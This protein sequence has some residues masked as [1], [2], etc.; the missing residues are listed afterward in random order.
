MDSQSS[1]HDLLST[2]LDGSNF[3]LWK[4][5]FGIFVQGK[6]LF[7]LLDGSARTPTDAKELDLWKLNNAKLEQDQIL[8]QNIF[9]AGLKEVLEERKKTR[10]VQFLMKLRPE[11]EP[12]RGSLLNREVTPALN[13]V[14]A[15]VLR[16]ETRLGTQVAMESTPLPSVALLAG[17]STTVASTGNTKRSVQCYEWQDFGHIAANCPKKKNICAYCKITGHHISDCRR[18]PNRSRTAHQAYQTNVTTSSGSFIAGHDFEKLIRDSIAA[19]LPEAISSALSASSSGT[20]NSINS[21]WHLDSGASNHMTGDLSQFSSLSSGVSKHVIH[22][23][24]GHTLPASG[25]GSVGNLSN[26]LYVPKL[27]ANLVSVGQLVDQNCVVKL[28]PNVCVVQN[29]KTGMTMATRRRFG[30]IFL[31]ESVHRH[32]HHCFLSV[33]AADVTCSNKLLTLWHNRIGYPHSSRLHHMLKSCLPA[34]HHIHSSL[35]LACTSCVGSKSHK[36]PFPSSSFAYEDPFDLVYSDVWG[37]SLIFFK[38]G[39]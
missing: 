27:K 34:A 9:K 4:F 12:I 29:L 33:S 14:L 10:V 28:S 7:G 2:K 1:S 18:R 5:H 39:I 37:P 21:T 8:G 17:K 25:I 3:S 20:S 31:L 38:D 23:A 22:T 16:E 19:A 35:F 30:R 13:V 32:L 24:N 6:G 26:V 36:L 11:F 15:A